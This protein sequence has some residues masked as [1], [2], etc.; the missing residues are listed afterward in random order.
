MR[1]RQ[2]KEIVYVE[3]GGDTSAKWSSGGLLGAGS[4]CSMRRVVGG[5]PRNLRE[6]VKLR[7]DRREGD[8]LTRSWAWQDT[9]GGLMEDERRT[10]MTMRGP[11]GPW[12]ARRRIAQES[13]S[14]D[15]RTPARGAVT[16]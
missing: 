14:G 1:G 12:P 8:E 7:P 13:S 5:Y 2:G 9:L 3:R 10:S 11:R 6:S 16:R 4:R 15:C